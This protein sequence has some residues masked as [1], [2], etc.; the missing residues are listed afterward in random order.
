ML[1]YTILYCVE[2]C[3]AILCAMTTGADFTKGV[4]P[5]PFIG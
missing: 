1:H 2:L 4:K 5:S 3:H